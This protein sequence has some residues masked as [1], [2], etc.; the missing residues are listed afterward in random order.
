VLA[1]GGRAEGSPHATWRR[2]MADKPK[3]LHS[4]ESIHAERERRLRQRYAGFS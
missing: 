2:D 4:G 1:S 3:H